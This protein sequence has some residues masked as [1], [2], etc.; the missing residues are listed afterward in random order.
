VG[1]VPADAT[2]ELG[3]IKLCNSNLSSVTGDFTASRI[4][5]GASSGT[6]LAATSLAPGACVVLAEDAGGDQ[7]GS[8]VTITQTSQGFVSATQ[9]RIDAHV[10]GSPP[11][12]S[13][14][15]F[16]N[17]ATA[18]VNIYHANTV[19]FLNHV[20]VP[21]VCDF[22]T[23]GRLVTSVGTDKVVISGNAGG[24]KP[25]G[26]I[27]G[28]FHIEANGVDNHVA[29]IEPGILVAAD[30]AWLRG[31][32]LTLLSNAIQYSGPGGHV[33]VDVGYPIEM[34]ADVV[35]LR[36]G[37]NGCGIPLERQQAIFDAPRGAEPRA[38]AAPGLAAS[39]ARAR[40]SST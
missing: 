35:L 1:D 18:F 23:F 24:S 32:L 10:D 39:R 37:D 4:A 13:S 22:I 27:L 12:F 29:D 28:E 14:G 16:S 31:I 6:V 33:M 11:T 3:K 15:P 2:P 17:G 9:D 30:P 21:P 38:D 8:D 20:D 40:T 36:V 34:P 5:I 7:V 19:T 25:G 26:G